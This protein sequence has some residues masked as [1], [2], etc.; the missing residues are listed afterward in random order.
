MNYELSI[1]NCE[2][3]IVYS[4]QLVEKVFK[5]YFPFVVRLY[6]LKCYVAACKSAVD[7]YRVPVKE[8]VYATSHLCRI[9]RF[10]YLQT[11]YCHACAL[12]VLRHGC[13]IVLRHVRRYKLNDVS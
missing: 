7:T 12:L 3:F 4:P 10:I 13:Q 1:L 11:L 9:S 6:N 2:L 5:V 8:V